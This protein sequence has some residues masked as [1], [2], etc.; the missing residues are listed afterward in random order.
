M[1]EELLENH[2]NI[3]YL[4]SHDEWKAFL[5]SKLDDTSIADHNEHVA[6]SKW[7]SLD[8]TKQVSHTWYYKCYNTKLN[9]T[10]PTV[11]LVSKGFEFEI[12]TINHL[13]YAIHPKTGVIVY[14]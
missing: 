7:R 12:D 6:H 5:E 2:D 1:I 4:C 11:L 9:M 14:D 10:R 8:S 13:A 3:I